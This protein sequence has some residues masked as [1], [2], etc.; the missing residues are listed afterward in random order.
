[1]FL[2]DSF[3]LFL[4][5]NYVTREINMS[6]YCCC[7]SYLVQLLPQRY[8]IP[9]DLVVV[10][11]VVVLSSQLIPQIS[12]LTFVTTFIPLLLVLSISALKDFVDDFVSFRF[13]S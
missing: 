7:Y 3:D 9:A 8:V 10:V 6:N 12:S 11:V 5:V 4:S 13:D 1:V 2:N